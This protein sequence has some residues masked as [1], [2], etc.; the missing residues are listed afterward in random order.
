[1]RR[2]HQQLHPSPVV[3]SL[4]SVRDSVIHIY[5]SYP[6]MLNYGV[7]HNFQHYQERK[8]GGRQGPSYAFEK[9]HL[10]DIAIFRR[11][12]KINIFKVSK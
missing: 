10:W 3:R 8:L 6:F 12:L 11:G 9:Y 1:M 2:T 5:Q 7:I 4:H